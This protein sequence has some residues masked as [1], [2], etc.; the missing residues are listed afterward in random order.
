MRKNR[1]FDDS[2]LEDRR[3]KPSLE[4]CMLGPWLKM[5]LSA[6]LCMPIVGLC[7]LSEKAAPAPPSTSSSGCMQTGGRDRMQSSQRDWASCPAGLAPLRADVEE[8][9]ANAHELS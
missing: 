7:E 4:W 6:M 5:L 9:T 8:W 2:S 1:R 3:W